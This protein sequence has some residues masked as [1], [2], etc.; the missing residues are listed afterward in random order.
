M[1][2]DR[3]VKD[4]WLELDVW[5]ALNSR[6]YQRRIKSW[7]INRNIIELRIIRFQVLKKKNWIYHLEKSVALSNGIVNIRL[8]TKSRRILQAKLTVKYDGT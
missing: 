2:N 8:E 6:L 5:L 4:S 7:K 3:I 1:F